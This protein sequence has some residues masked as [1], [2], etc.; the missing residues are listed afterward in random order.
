MCVSVSFVSLPSSFPLFP[1]LTTPPFLTPDSSH[2]LATSYFCSL[3]VA[4]LSKLIALPAYPLPTEQQSEYLKL[5][6]LIST[7]TIHP[8]VNP[9]IHAHIHHLSC[10]TI[11]SNVNNCSTVH[12]D[13]VCGWEYAKQEGR[14]A[15]TVANTVIR[16][17]QRLDC[18]FTTL[19][20][21]Y[22]TCWFSG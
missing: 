2:S 12:P 20:P 18:E 8:S 5:D 22:L 9:I 15:Q 11:M 13:E 4:S 21:N 3:T 10:S 19:H 7:S 14:S 1:L 17:Y 6:P 16:H